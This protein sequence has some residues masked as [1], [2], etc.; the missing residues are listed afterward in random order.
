MAMNGESCKFP[1]IYEGVTYTSCAPLK[2]TL[3]MWCATSVD[4]NDNM[5]GVSI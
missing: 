4:D 2:K 1:F 5:V 3:D